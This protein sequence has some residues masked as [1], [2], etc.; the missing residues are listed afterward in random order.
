MLLF[1]K[2]FPD[3]WNDTKPFLRFFANERKLQMF[4]LVSK[5]HG[6]WDMKEN[7]KSLSDITRHHCDMTQTWTLIMHQTANRGLQKTQTCRNSWSWEMHSEGHQHNWTAGM[8]QQTGPRQGWLTSGGRRPNASSTL[9]H[10]HRHHRSNHNKTN[11]D[12]ITLL[13]LLLIL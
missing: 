8:H 5:W 7:E 1:S 9:W 12:T 2:S 13:D 3:L 10:A 4:S 11:I 6:S